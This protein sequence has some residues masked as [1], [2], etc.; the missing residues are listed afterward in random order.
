MTIC[1]QHGD[2]RSLEPLGFVG[3]VAPQH[4]GVH[5]RQA[6]GDCLGCHETEITEAR[7]GKRKTVK[8]LRLH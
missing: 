7:S 4:P 6:Q 3:V 2:D 5:A 1:Q 8:Y